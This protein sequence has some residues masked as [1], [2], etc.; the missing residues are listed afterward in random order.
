MEYARFCH[1]IGELDEAIKA[2]EVAVQRKERP[3]EFFTEDDSWDGTPERL[4]SEWREERLAGRLMS[5]STQKP[6]Q[7]PPKEGA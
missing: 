1:N 2:L 7:N 6:N 4:L 5:E 3:K